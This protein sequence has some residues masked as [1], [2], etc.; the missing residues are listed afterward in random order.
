MWINR[1]LPFVVPTDS[2]GSSELFSLRPR[3]SIGRPKLR[4]HIMTTEPSNRFN[5]HKS[6]HGGTQVAVA[7]L[8][9]ALVVFAFVAGMAASA[10][11]AHVGAEL[12]R[13]TVDRAQKGDRLVGGSVVQTVKRPRAVTVPRPSDGNLKLPVGCDPLVSPIADDWL[14]RVAGRCVS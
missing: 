3:L 9:A 12:A 14:G 5:F 13:Q 8:A 4:C 11:T 1:H 2:A 6:S 10:A 7:C